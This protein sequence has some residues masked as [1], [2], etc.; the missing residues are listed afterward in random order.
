MSRKSVEAHFRE[1]MSVDV[2]S[3]DKLLQLLPFKYHIEQITHLRDLEPG[4]PYD[5]FKP[6]IGYV[7]TSV[8]SGHI[9]E[10]K[11]SRYFWTS[12]NIFYADGTKI[13]LHSSN[14]KTDDK[15]DI[16]DEEYRPVSPLINY[17]GKYIR[18]TETLYRWLENLGV[19]IKAINEIKT[20][21]YY[22]TVYF[23][24]GVACPVRSS[25]DSDEWAYGTKYLTIKASEIAQILHDIQDEEL[26]IKVY[27][28]LTTPQNPLHPNVFS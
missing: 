18:P 1:E 26:A 28:V 11:T 17:D 12:T 22:D 23:Y 27:K 14:L 16:I 13:H 9:K 15:D 8:P 25:R 5:D 20:Q 6:E 24:P 21:V 7:I 10:I 4:E 2:I 19:S 3:A